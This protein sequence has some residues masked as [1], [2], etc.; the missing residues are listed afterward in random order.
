MTPETRFDQ[1]FAAAFQDRHNLI[2]FL[3]G[4]N[5][6]AAR[7]RPPDGEWSILQGLEHV[8]L[9]EQYFRRRLLTILQ[10]AEASG[11]W[12]N[13]PPNPVKMSAAALRRREQG[14]VAAPE[15]L[16]PRGRIDYDAMRQALLAEREASHAALLPYRCRDLRQLVF[17]HPRYGERHVYDVIEYSGIHDALHQE[18]MERVTRSPGYP[19]ATLDR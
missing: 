5:D 6:E 9:S 12:H 1:A 19:Q 8:M 16:V 14:F 3:T 2:R 10:E 18:Q 7:W 15:E 4:V 13:A 11:N 17:P